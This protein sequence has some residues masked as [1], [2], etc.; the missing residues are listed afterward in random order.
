MASHPARKTVAIDRSPS[1]RVSRVA[2][3]LVELLVVIGI[4]AL[5]ISI[6]LPSLNRAR[7][8]AQQAVCLSNLRQIAMAAYNYAVDNRGDCV[9]SAVNAGWYASDTIDGA[10]G[11]AAMSWNYEYVQPTGGGALV[12]SFKR[13]FLGRY[14]G[15]DKVLECPTVAIMELPL[16]APNAPAT[17]YGFALVG[18][19]RFANIQRAS[20]TAIA[21]DSIQFSFTTGFSRPT[22]LQ[23][24][25]LSQ[26]DTFHG[27]HVNATGNLAFFDGHAEPVLAQK[28]TQG[29]YDPAA[30]VTLKRLAILQANHLGPAC[31][32]IIDQSIT[33]YAAYS[34]ECNASYDYYFWSNKTMHR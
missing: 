14:L 32:M 16:D 15:S 24:T 22:Q 5:L 20:E 28:R 6:L 26:I 3:T 25:G 31:P 17:S 29:S 12:Y 30:T 2:F 1:R 11:P 21:G 18:A 27:R 23:R 33:S 10:T 4:I 34:T 19:K 8:A 7:R 13:G 9:P